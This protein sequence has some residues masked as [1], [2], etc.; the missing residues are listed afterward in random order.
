VR[1]LGAD[2]DLTR[3]GGVE[4][5]A[6]GQLGRVADLPANDEALRVRADGLEGLETTVG[7][8]GRCLGKA[9]GAE[10]EVDY[11]G[12]HAGPPGRG[13]CRPGLVLGLAFR[14]RWR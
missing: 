12:E 14:A 10:E 7:E 6:L 9:G 3:V 13:D 8:E 11:G 2:G 5:P 4:R 1:A